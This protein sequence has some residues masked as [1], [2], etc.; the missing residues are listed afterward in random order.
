VTVT[1]SHPTGDATGGGPAARSA[2]PA[3]GAGAVLAAVEA[4]GPTI[5]GRAAEIEAA[6]RVPADLLTELARAGAFRLLLPASHGGI[7][8][9]LPSALAV[10][11]AMA[12]ADAS[13][14]WIV[15]IGGGAWCDLAGLARPSFDALFPGDR[16]V[17]VAGA[18]N[19]SGSAVPVDGGYRI[20]GRW[21]FASGC[22]HADVLY[23]NCIEAG[24]GGEPGMRI[25]VFDPGQVVIE[26]TWHV[27]G[28]RG[29]GSHHFHVDGV[30]VPADR[31]AVPMAAPPCID[32]T[33]VHV[34]P[35]SLFSLAVASV[36]LGAARGALDDVLALAAGRTPLL[37][38]APLAANPLFHHRAA[39]ADTELRAAWALLAQ[40]AGEVWDTATRRD[41]FPLELRGRVR[42]AAAW[43]T[44]RAAAAAEAAYHAGGGTA[45]YDRSPLQRRFRDVHAIT[46]HFLVKADTLT[47]AGAVLAGQDPPVP[48][49]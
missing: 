34:P 17:V 42:A 38:P 27:S 18:F 41:P 7:G 28:L 36:A 39:V 23:G 15:A 12:R 47:T 40:A 2:P 21:G 16:D 45:L 6:R 46:Q 33:V 22:E 19:P 5:A 1:T 37:D 43:A 29:T 24:S 48:I 8:A 26:D 30:V 13:S 3:P 49:F 9:D 31:T 11:E 32:E 10:Y 4:L 44:G 35:P 20:T 14:A 25:A